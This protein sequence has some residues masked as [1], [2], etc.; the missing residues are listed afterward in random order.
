MKGG[1]PHRVP[2]YARAIAII[3]ELAP[4]R[5]GSGMVFPGQDGG[6]SNHLRKKCYLK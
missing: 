6:L 1:K 2:L 3:D 4:L 5:N